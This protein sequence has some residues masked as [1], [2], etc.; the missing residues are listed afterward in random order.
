MLGCQ[1]DEKLG[2]FLLWR[3]NWR[4]KG[5]NCGQFN[6][7]INSDSLVCK[8]D[9][10]NHSLANTHGETHFKVCILSRIDLRT[11]SL[12]LVVRFTVDLRECA[13]LDFAEPRECFSDNWR[14]TGGGAT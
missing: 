8:R 7:H 4:A 14:A 5:D 9:A 10:G 12:R 1:R 2:R 6:G 13:L 11:N 3:H